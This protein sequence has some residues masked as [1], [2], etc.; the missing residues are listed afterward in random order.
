MFLQKVP[1]EFIPHMSLLGL[2][3]GTMSIC[4]P[5]SSPHWA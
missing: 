4:G 2:S 3:D 1:H 5:V